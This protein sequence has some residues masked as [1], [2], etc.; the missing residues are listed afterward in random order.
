[1]HRR[2]FTAGAAT[3]AIGAGRLAAPGLAQ[4]AARLLRFV[5]QS[6]LASPVWTTATIATIHGDMVWDTLYGV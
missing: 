6:N 1:M 2:V 3:L 4:G 5:P